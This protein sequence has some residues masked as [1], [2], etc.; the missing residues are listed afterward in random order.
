MPIRRLGSW[1]TDS[2]IFKYEATLLKRDDLTLTTDDSI[3]PAAFLTRNLNP[4][5]PEL[6][7]EHRCLDLISYQTKV[8]PDLN[9]TSFQTGK[10]VFV[11]GF[12]QVIKGKRHNEYS[13]IDG[14]TLTETES[15]R[16]PNDWSA[17]TCELF[18]LY[19]ALGWARWLMPVIPAFWEAEVGGSRGQ[20]IKTILANTVG[21]TPSLLKIQKI[22]QVWWW[23]A[24]V[25]ATAEAEAGEWRKP[26]RRS[27]Q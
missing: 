5:T 4:Q 2:R 24:I 3:N 21:E 19:Q 1:L 15:E 8:R 9:E 7:P 27:L 22:S 14:D 26:G 17:Q 12:S 10:H 18:T 16:L 11:D 25:P 13:M 20:E 6:C 23:A